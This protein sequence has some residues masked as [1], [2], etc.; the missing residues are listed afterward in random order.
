MRLHQGALGA[1]GHV[2]APAARQR[3]TV[4]QAQQSNRNRCHGLVPR[5][6]LVALTPQALATLLE[7]ALPNSHRGRALP[8]PAA[9]E[10]TRATRLSRD[11]LPRVVCYPTATSAACRLLRR[12]TTPRRVATTRAQFPGYALAAYSPGSCYPLGGGDVRA[13]P[14]VDLGLARL[15]TTGHPGHGRFALR[16][17]PVVFAHMTYC[18]AVQASPLACVTSARPRVAPLHDPLS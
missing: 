2:G 5:S 16:T 6:G 11:F 17:V 8:K 3:G 7:S 1:R 18:P 9:E 10:S 13:T 14:A 12:P 4:H 15:P